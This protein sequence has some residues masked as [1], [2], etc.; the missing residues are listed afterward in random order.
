M[1]SI[2]PY[3]CSPREIVTVIEETFGTV[4]EC[5]FRKHIYFSLSDAAEHSFPEPLILVSICFASG[6]LQWRKF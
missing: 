6:R 2:L 4:S 1:K 5:I 3:F